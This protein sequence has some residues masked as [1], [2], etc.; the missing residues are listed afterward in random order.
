M[1][2]F[3]GHLYTII[4]PKNT[5]NITENQLLTRTSETQKLNDLSPSMTAQAEL[6]EQELKGIAGG[7]PIV[8]FGVGVLSILAANEIERRRGN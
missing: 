2:L 3:N 4:Q 8:T 1:M 5:M 7:N 6:N